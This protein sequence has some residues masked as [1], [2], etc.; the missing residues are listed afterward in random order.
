MSTQE[1]RFFRRELINYWIKT[2]KG[3]MPINHIISLIRLDEIEKYGL[4]LNI[5]SQYVTYL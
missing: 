5:Y 2:C 1:K 3:I 4:T